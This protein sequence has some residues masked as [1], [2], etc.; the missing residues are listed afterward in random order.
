LSSNDAR[1]AAALLSGWNGV[2]APNSAPALLFEIWFRRHLIEA[3]AETLA[4]GAFAHFEAGDIAGY[5][6]LQVTELVL[7][8]DARFGQ[9]PE[10]KRDAI[11][12]ATLAAAWRETV[13]RCGDQPASW[14]WDNLHHARFDHPLSHLL[15]DIAARARRIGKGGSGL[16]PNA[17]DYGPDDF[18]MTVGASFRMVLDIGAWDEGVFVNAPGQSGDPHSAHYDDHLA[19]WGSEEFVPLLY[20]RGAVEAAA[21]LRILLEPAGEAQ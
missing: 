3:V 13:A 20:S 2:I 1:Q 12:D 14:R 19:A 16:T 6:T 17:G 9:E 21:E 11:V 4:P 8:P 7:Q 18:R 5:D 10:A 15:P